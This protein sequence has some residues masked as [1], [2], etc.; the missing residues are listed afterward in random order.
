M[1]VALLSKDRRLSFLLS[2]TLGPG[3]KLVSIT[4]SES[5]KRLAEEGSFGAWIVDTDSLS[6]PRGD[7]RTILNN[8]S[9]GA[10]ARVIVMTTD[11]DRGEI[12]PISEEFGYDCIRKPPAIRELKLRLQRAEDGQLLRGELEK[13]RR[14]LQNVT[15]LDQLTGC[16]APMLCVYDLVRRVA[17]LDASVLI[18]GES[19]TGKELVARAIHNLGNRSNRPFL[20]VS[21]GAIPETLIEAELFGHEKGAYT[22]AGGQRHGYLEQAGDGTLLLDEVGE[23]SL[24]TQVK[25]LRVLQQRE[26]HRL[27]STSAIPLRARVVFATHRNLQEM[28]AQGTFRQDLFYRINVMNIN[29]PAL[30][31]RAEDIPMLVQLLLQRY[32]DLH[33]KPID[34]IEPDALRLLGR[35]PWGGNVRELENVIQHA[36]IM[37]EGD[38]ILTADLPP[39]IQDLE[40]VEDADDLPAGSFDRLV[41][42][43]KVKLVKEAIA[44][45]HGNKTLASQSL[46]ISRAYLH[47][48]IRPQAPDETPG[49][50]EPIEFAPRAM[51]AVQ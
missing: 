45:C 35:Y 50:N 33:R 29:V 39:V 18:T 40:S 51:A 10:G 2:S 34:G 7:W 4:S 21:C 37:A 25:L 20:A 47:R 49:P 38:Q 48:L 46:S 36:V 14:S 6:D 24:A 3:F 17:K 31:E 28:V 13:T 5:A 23:I 26:F 12:L 19:G 27:G 44:N 15:G 11:E 9:L 43:Y 42:D 32:S 1:Q 16:S 8:S 41:R 30:R 22:G